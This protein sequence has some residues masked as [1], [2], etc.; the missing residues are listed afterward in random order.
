MVYVT[1][2][3]PTADATSFH[4]FGRVMSGTS[5]IYSKFSILLFRLLLNYYFPLVVYAR[6]Q[7][8]VMGE[9]YTLE[10]EEDSRIGQVR[11]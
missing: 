1:K 11:I 10:D 2:Q 5:M 9:N 4:V 6:Q 7:V 3:Y 8:K